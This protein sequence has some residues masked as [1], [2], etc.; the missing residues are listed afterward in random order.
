VT[1]KFSRRAQR[2]FETRFNDL[3]RQ[4]RTAAA[5]F[6]EDVE[7]AVTFLLLHPRAGRI[8]L[9]KGR[10]GPARRWN[11]PPMAIFYDLRGEDLYL[12]RIR[13]VARRPITR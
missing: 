1:L 3:R 13:H 2:D 4:S 10:R 12:V 7:Q 11:I 5:A 8:V 9:L 6:L